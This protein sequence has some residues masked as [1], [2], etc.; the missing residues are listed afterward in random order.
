M[1]VYAAEVRATRYAPVAL[2]WA[3]TMLVPYMPLA[4]FTDSY[5]HKAT[6]SQ[7]RN[8]LQHPS[9]HAA[10]EAPSEVGLPRNAAPR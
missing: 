6:V 2:P 10:R 9:D 8:K 1:R 4:L 7:G 3:H 5:L